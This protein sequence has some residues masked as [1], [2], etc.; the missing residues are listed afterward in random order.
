MKLVVTHHQVFICFWIE[1]NYSGNENKATG[2]VK[3]D[4][5]EYATTDG[6]KYWYNTGSGETSWEEPNI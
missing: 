2:N 3:G 4:W 1:L 5:I 6:N